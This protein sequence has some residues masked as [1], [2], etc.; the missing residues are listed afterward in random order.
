MGTIIRLAD[1]ARA[2]AGSRASDD[3]RAAIAAKISAVIPAAFAVGALTIASHHSA[4]MASRLHHL[5][6]MSAPAPISSAIA[7]RVDQ[8][9][10]MARNV[11]GASNMEFPLGH[12]GLNCKANVADDHRLGS[13]DNPSMSERL[14]ETEEKALFIGRVRA[15]REARFPTQKPICVLL[16]VAQGTYKHWEKRSELPHKLIPKFCAA[17]GVS[18]EWLL[19]GEGDGPVVAEIPRDIPK[20]IHKARRRKAA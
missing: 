18:M 14:S 13:G 12:S 3:G 16:D 7:L 5:L 8:S 1:H 15:A 10:I 6:T 9:S 4:G 11:P 17:C 2:S 19:T 20:R